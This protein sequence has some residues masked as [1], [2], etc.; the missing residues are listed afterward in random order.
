MARAKTLNYAL[1]LDG[2]NRL[3]AP[4]ESASRQVGNFVSKYREASKKILSTSKKTEQSASVFEKI[5]N[6]K[7]SPRSTKDL[8]VQQ[9]EVKRLDVAI[10]Q[11][12]EY[13]KELAETSREWLTLTTQ[14]SRGIK[15]LSQTEREM[16]KAHKAY[17]D[18]QKAIFSLR[19]E[20]DRAARSEG[21]RSETVIRL[22]T[23][24][25]RLREEG[26]RLRENFQAQRKAL[27]EQQKTIDATRMKSQR[28]KKEKE[29]LA[30]KAW[31][32]RKE[33]RSLGVSTKT[34]AQAKEQVILKSKQIENALKRQTRFVTKLRE[35]EEKLRQARDSKSGIMDRAQAATIAGAGGLATGQAILRTVMSPVGGAMEFEKSMSSVQARL[36]SEA[37]YQTEEGA[38]KAQKIMKELEDISREIGSE[39]AFSA[40][41]VAA[42]VEELGKQ[43]VAVDQINKD[44][45]KNMLNV[46]RAGELSLDRAVG[47]TAGLLNAYQKDITADN[48]QEFGD[49]IA[50]ITLSSSANM[51][52]LVETF[53]EA[54]PVA[55]D[56]I[57][58]K[59]LASLTTLMAQVGI[60]G[61]NAGT[62]LKNTML[63]LASPTSKGAAA[64]ES[65]GVS[66]I[67]S[68]NNLRN[69]PDVL[70]DIATELDKRGLGSAQRKSM[71]ESI[72]GREGL[73]GFSRLIAAAG[74]TIE[75]EID[76]EKKVINGLDNMIETMDKAGGM[77]ANISE[78]L[79][80]NLTTDVEKLRSAMFEMSIVLG[81]TLIPVLRVGVQNLTSFVS[82]VTKLANDY[83]R[84]T[85]ALGISAAVVGGLVTVFSALTLAIGSVVGVLSSM[86]IGLVGIKAVAGVAALALLPVLKVLA[87]GGL[88]AAGVGAVGYGG[89][90]LY[91]KFFGEKPEEKI[92]ESA[93]QFPADAPQNVTVT[94]NID[95]KIPEG[96]NPEAVA[97]QVKQEIQNSFDKFQLAYRERA[98]D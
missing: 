45:V 95:L 20:I 75:V 64:L 3:G 19:N 72:V 58:F 90:K 62:A 57:D 53:K 2:V 82:W 66:A 16:K 18:N 77:T 51:E 10:R 43:G 52:D 83:P 70:K 17:Q 79:E 40:M 22:R 1:R 86:S 60:K 80:D 7:H 27:S 32:L 56:M 33:F 35:A 30:Q 88:V 26:V 5:V 65:L 98:F 21:S 36:L 6:P 92:A 84:V 96:M 85:K 73:A 4:L 44:V 93:S 38:A 91:E 37:K 42:G 47:L 24:Q 67:D 94:N 15:A 69:I 54:A 34:L 23:E 87:I 78:I 48:L 97:K 81:N 71:I 12:S 14:T 11:F 8:L 29:K 13:K 41:E 31:D 76:G 59:E 68:E 49:A 25:A 61:S 55:G 9:E 28:L 46:A 50:Q 39:T 74:Q 89:Y 63:A